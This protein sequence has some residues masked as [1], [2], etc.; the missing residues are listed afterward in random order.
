MGGM[1]CDNP[2]ALFGITMFMTA[3]WSKEFMTVVVFF[4]SL[5]CE[6]VF[7]FFLFCAFLAKH[8]RRSFCKLF[9]SHFSSVFSWSYIVYAHLFTLPTAF[10]D[11]YILKNKFFWF[12]SLFPPW[13]LAGPI[14]HYT[15]FTQNLWYQT[16]FGNFLD[17]RS[18]LSF[19]VCQA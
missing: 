4:V 15:V 11:H 1:S 2:P 6:F 3:V 14:G 8:T 19:K 7:F 9:I 13:S 5:S 17:A 10:T 18:M 12:L 16:I